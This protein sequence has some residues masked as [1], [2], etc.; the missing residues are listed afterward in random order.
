MSKSG[1]STPS[2]SDNVARVLVLYSGGTIGMLST[3]SGYL[4]EKGYLTVGQTVSEAPISLLTRAG[5]LQDYLK[6][7]GRFHDPQGL[8]VS[9]QI[10]S[11]VTK[12]HIR[13]AC[14][15]FRIRSQQRRTAN[16][17]RLPLE[18]TRR[19]QVD[20]NRQQSARIPHNLASTWPHR[21]KRATPHRDRRSAAARKTVTSPSTCLQT[22]S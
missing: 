7:Q 2:S 9:N 3:P 19:V 15:S 17:Q 12:P 5:S 10:A 8:S 18:A 1:L 13:S 11:R 6:S 16:G 22:R 20:R 4:P 21:P 14:S